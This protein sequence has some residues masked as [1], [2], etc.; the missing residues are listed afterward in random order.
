MKKLL[1]AAI[2]VL[3][4]TLS[5]TLTA[6]IFAKPETDT[7]KGKGATAYWT[8][9]QGAGYVYVAIGEENPNQN[10]LYIEGRHDTAGPGKWYLKGYTENVDFDWNLNAKGNITIVTDLTVSYY[11]QLADGT[12][13]LRGTRLHHVKV[14]FILSPS[15]QKDTEPGPWKTAVGY[16]WIDHSATAPSHNND[17]TPSDWALLYTPTANSKPLTRPPTLFP[18]FP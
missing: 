1:L 3:A 10:W 5:T 6:T 15:T 16:Y 17:G 8:V 13:A 9:G 4:L 7:S 12:L 11:Q 14:S 18:A 2:F